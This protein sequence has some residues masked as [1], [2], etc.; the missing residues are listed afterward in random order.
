MEVHPNPSP[1]I[2]GAL[3]NLF[4]SV[5]LIFQITI[6]I[7][8][9]EPLAGYIWQI[10]IPDFSTAMPTSILKFEKNLL[11]G[12]GVLH[13]DEIVWN[14]LGLTLVGTVLSRRVSDPPTSLIH[15]KV[16]YALT[17]PVLGRKNRWL[18]KQSTDEPF[19]LFP[20]SF[21]CL[22]YI[23]LP[24]YEVDILFIILL[25]GFNS[26]HQVKSKRM[27]EPILRLGDAK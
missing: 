10:Y 20:F 27:H 12:I 9:N 19:F 13:R 21:S 4:A 8:G 1:F 24:T 26:I 22:F 25:K 5:G 7:V 16:D 6:F 18:S 14:R 17:R 2:L 3:N 15:A 11:P 23:H